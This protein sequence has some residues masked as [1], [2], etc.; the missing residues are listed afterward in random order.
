[1]STKMNRRTAFTTMAGGYAFLQTP[2]PIGE[3]KAATHTGPND[4]R[5]WDLHAEW[6]RTHEEYDRCSAES[7]RLQ[8]QLPWPL[9]RPFERADYINS[10]FGLEA[11]IELRHRANAKRK[12]LLRAWGADALEERAEAAFTR[13]NDCEDAMAQIVADTAHGAQAQIE[14]VDYWRRIGDLNE[15]FNGE[16]MQQLAWRVFEFVQRQRAAE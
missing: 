9:R 12:P 11:E 10:R 3:A 2:L 5:L 1:M 13:A 7:E 16:T 6:A 4:R 8:A 15:A 14:I